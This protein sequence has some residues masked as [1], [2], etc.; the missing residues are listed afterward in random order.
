MAILV[1]VFG[2][3]LLF[4]G[5]SFAEEGN[6]PCRAFLMSTVAASTNIYLFDKD[7]LS[8]FNG[9]LGK[10]LIFPLA[11]SLAEGDA[12]LGIANIASSVV[13]IV[14][15]EIFMREVWVNINDEG[16]KAVVGVKVAF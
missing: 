9:R 7:N 16:T 10:S 6:I 8:T 12:K 13:G 5:N 11:Y 14:L 2:V 3:S 4:A 1:L 15:S